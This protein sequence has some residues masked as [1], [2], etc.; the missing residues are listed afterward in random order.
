[1][2]DAVLSA[3]SSLAARQQASAVNTTPPQVI[4]KDDQ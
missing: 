1:L 2:Y 3:K 4:A